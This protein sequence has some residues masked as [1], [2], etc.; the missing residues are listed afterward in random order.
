MTCE[1]DGAN[2]RLPPGPDNALALTSAGSHAALSLA[3]WRLLGLQG[4]MNASHFMAMPLLAVYCT[5]ALGLS[6]ATTGAVLAVY[7][8]GA[9]MTP[10]VVAPLV[11]RFGRW[12]AVSWGLFL[13]GVVF[14]VSCW[15][16][17]RQRHS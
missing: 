11:D 2:D 13:R 8:A 3:L 6:A 14:L 5:S 16:P 9:R 15:R 17:V 10:V 1:A 7:F 4:V 12:P